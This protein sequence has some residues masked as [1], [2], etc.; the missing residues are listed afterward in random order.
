MRRARLPKHPGPHSEP[1][2]LTALL[3]RH[4]TSAACRRLPSEVPIRSSGGRLPASAENEQC[5]HLPCQIPDEVFGRDSAGNA[6]SEDA[7][8]GQRCRT[9]LHHAEMPVEDEAMHVRWFNTLAGRSALDLKAEELRQL[10]VAGGVPLKHR[11]TL[12]PRWF[13]A[14]GNVDVERLQEE[15]SPRAAGQIEADI[16]RTRPQQF[17]PS[18]RRCLRRVLRAYA[19]ANPS[20][21]YCQGMNDIAAVFI[22]LGF[23]EATALRGCF[24]VLHGCC[25]GYHGRDLAGLRLDAKVLEVLAAR[26]LPDETWRRF[27]ALGVPLEVLAAEHLLTLGSHSLPLGA[28]AQL[29]D[30]VL[31]EGSLAVL[32]SFLALLSLYLPAG[33]E[34]DCDNPPHGLN[35]NTNS[36]DEESDEDL[37]AA[38]RR[39][40]RQG[41]ATDCGRFLTEVQR[42]LRLLPQSEITQLRFELASRRK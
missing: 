35:K 1:R 21:G 4:Q 9:R 23:D 28:V 12:W 33:E 38:F 36:M 14:P 8:Q 32:A 18:E 25:P 40:A 19:A 31:Q 29:W 30:T 10:L 13:A 6:N 22:L 39:R 26:L 27:L 20:V 15:V 34:D 42:F 7:L 5:Q 37:V 3:P 24:S 2:E 41:V 11:H 17:G 16:E